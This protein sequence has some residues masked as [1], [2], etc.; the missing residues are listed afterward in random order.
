MYNK[1]RNNCLYEPE[2]CEFEFGILH[3]FIWFTLLKL[4]QYLLVMN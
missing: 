1:V 3:Q 4:Q 2:L